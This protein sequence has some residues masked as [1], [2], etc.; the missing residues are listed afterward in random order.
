[1]RFLYILSF[2]L[3]FNLFAQINNK[4]TS[5]ADCDNGKFC[6]GI[7][8]CENKKCVRGER[9]CQQDGFVCDESKNACTERMCT[10]DFMCGNDNLFC[11]GKEVCNP[12]LGK[13]YLSMSYGKG[14]WGCHRV[15]KPCSSGETCVEERRSC[16]RA[17]CS[18]SDVRDR[19][20]D[21]HANIQ[22]GGDDCDDDD[23][24][25]NPGKKEYCDRENLDE[26]CDPKTIASKDEDRDKD[27][28]Y[29]IR[30][31]NTSSG[32]DTLCGTDCD[33]TNPFIVPRAQS[34]P[35]DGSPEVL[36]CG[37]GFVQCGNNK[38]CHAQP[39][40]TGICAPPN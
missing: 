39:N 37:W 4:C 16:E 17:D 31:C 33:D 20:G 30:C 35:V 3:S 27:G 21:G 38:V 40:G 5:N 26:D 34:C 6:D 22:C 13:G 1:M 9:P 25:I 18:R 12:A 7:E 14:H 8:R 19:D 15:E 23:A 24:R 29:P 2:I 11:N 36:V 32:G 28:F 10:Q